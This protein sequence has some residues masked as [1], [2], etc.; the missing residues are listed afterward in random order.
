MKDQLQLQEI[1]GYLPY[2][3]QVQMER[4][5][6]PK[7]IEIVYLNV[8]NIDQIESPKTWRIK[9]ILRPMSDLI[10][11]FGLASAIED[12]LRGKGVKRTV[13]LPYWAIQWLS[14]LNH[15]GSHY[16]WQDLIGQGKAISIHDIP[17]TQ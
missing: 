1:A 8:T 16:D 10:G 4:L 2:G 14:G 11:Q 12:Y 13:D 6:Y 17:A 9:P 5:R 3:L 7:G 15:D